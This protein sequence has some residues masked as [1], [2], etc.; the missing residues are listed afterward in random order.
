MEFVGDISRD[1]LHTMGITSDD[2]Q[3]TILSRSTS[4]CLPSLAP[5]AASGGSADKD[6]QLADAAKVKHEEEKPEEEQEG[7][8]EAVKADGKEEMEERKRIL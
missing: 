8:E 5:A 4:L 2:E 3:K 1:D 7:A 6:Q